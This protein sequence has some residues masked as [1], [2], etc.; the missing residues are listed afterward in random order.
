MTQMDTAEHRRDYPSVAQVAMTLGVSALTVRRRIAAGEL[1]AIKL[2]G[3]GASV[4]VP[5]R[6][7]EMWLWSTPS[8]KNDGDA[9]NGEETEDRPGRHLPLLDVRQRGCRRPT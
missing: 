9:E 5:R 4:R 3:P 7:L 1:P 2:G 6:A 8:E